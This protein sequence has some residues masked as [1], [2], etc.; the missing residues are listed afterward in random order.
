LSRAVT[1]EEAKEL[2]ATLLKEELTGMVNLNL[3]WYKIP[4]ANKIR[5]ILTINGMKWSDPIHDDE[6]DDEDYED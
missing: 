1:K 4:T 5:G 2:E 6:T 3:W